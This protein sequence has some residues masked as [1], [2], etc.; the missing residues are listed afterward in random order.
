M[1]IENKSPTVTTSNSFTFDARIN[2]NFGLIVSGPP[3]S[4]KTHF[5]LNLLKNSD[6]LFTEKFTYI[7]WFYGQHNKTIS[8]L[9]KEFPHVQTVK[10]L[11]E[12]IEHYI[13]PQEKNEYG[14][15]IY[16][17]LMTSS[18]ENADILSLVT[19]KCQHN[20]ISWILILQDIFYKSKNR[21]TLM[22]AA[23]YHTIF[24]NPLDL[25]IIDLMSAKLLPDDR[26]TFMQIFRQ[27]A[28]VPN[29]YLHI[30][31]KQ[32]TPNCARFRTN[33]FEECQRVFIPKRLLNI[34]ESEI[35]SE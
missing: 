25:S 9:E 3:I 29:G 17:D 35:Y 32:K 30:D 13:K 28:M 23:H 18:T 24:N 26:K 12:N 20:N 1:E 10:G 7:V 19:T 34:C 27:A 31:G 5:V 2:V 4:G 14:L 8:L 11:P 22:R 33:I 16:D 15:H 21:L 6:R